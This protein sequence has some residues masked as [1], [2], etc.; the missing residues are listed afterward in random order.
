VRYLGYG[1][2]T[3]SLVMRGKTGT[4]RYIEAIHSWDSLMKFSAVKYD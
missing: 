3:S 1:A 2:E 4:I